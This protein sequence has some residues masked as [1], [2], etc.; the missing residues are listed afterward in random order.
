MLHVGI[1]EGEIAISSEM[2]PYS[3][4]K[5]LFILILVAVIGLL[6]S[7]S[8]QGGM[9][10]DCEEISNRDPEDL[11]PYEGYGCDYVE[12]IELCCVILPLILALI[13]FFPSIVPHNEEE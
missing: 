10:E 12:M 2:E 1:K 11:E 8:I 13:L 7:S 6:W 5:L 3:P 9:S 4:P